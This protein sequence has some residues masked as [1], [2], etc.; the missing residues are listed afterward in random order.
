MGRGTRDQQWALGG[1]FSMHALVV[2]PAANGKQT[3]SPHPGLEATSGQGELFV[4]HARGFGTEAGIFYAE[5]N[6]TYGS[7]TG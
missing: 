4:T 5:Y 6:I 2:V 7:L 3:T 1:A